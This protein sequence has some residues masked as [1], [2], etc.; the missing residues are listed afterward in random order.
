MKKFRVEHVAVPAVALFFGW[1][2]YNLHLGTKKQEFGDACRLL[3]AKHSVL[4]GLEP[5]RVSS[6]VI[7]GE[8]FITEDSRYVS[9]EV[10]F[11]K[12]VRVPVE[13]IEAAWARRKK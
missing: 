12:P 1:I 9:P 8:C 6:Q 11:T 7:E 13:D 4:S 2:F 3:E 5:G 10:G